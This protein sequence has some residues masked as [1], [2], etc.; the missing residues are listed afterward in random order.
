MD[1]PYFFSETKLDEGSIFQ[2]LLTYNCLR[3]FLKETLFSRR[4]HL[5]RRKIFHIEIISI[6]I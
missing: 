5:I 2:T 3:R 4:E 6:D 1:I